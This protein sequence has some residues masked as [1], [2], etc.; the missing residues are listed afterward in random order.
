MWLS[1]LR[2]YDLN[3][4]TELFLVGMSLQGRPAFETN[5]KS[6]RNSIPFGIHIPGETPHDLR[7]L[8]ELQKPQLLTQ[9]ELSSSNVTFIAIERG[10]TN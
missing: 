5:V 2:G 1:K 10:D 3:A 8:S 7:S 6:D 4:K 9:M